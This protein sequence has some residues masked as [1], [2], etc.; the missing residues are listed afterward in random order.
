LIAEI[1]IPM[2][3]YTENRNLFTTSPEHNIKQRDTRFEVY[4]AVAMKNAVFW[5]I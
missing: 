1:N 5:D 4:T 3:R 2:K